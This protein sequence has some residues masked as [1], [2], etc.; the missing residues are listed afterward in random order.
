MSDPVTLRLDP[1]TRKRLDKLAQAT[2]RSRA[3]LAADAVRQYLDLNEWQIAAIEA[4]VSEANRGQLID[5]ARLKAKWEKRL[6]AAL[7]KAR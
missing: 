3:A 7:D 5:H 4:G 6:A 1:E 2:E